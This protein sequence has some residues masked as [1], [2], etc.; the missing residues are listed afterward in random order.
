MLFAVLSSLVSF[1]VA[2][3]YGGPPTTPT[4]TAPAPAAPIPSAP[5]DTAGHVNINVAP[6]GSFVFSPA[7]VTAPN[8]TVVTFWFPSSS[9]QHSVT[10]SSFADP[11]TYLA[12][13]SNT[14]AGFDSGL[15]AADQFTITITNDQAPIW[16]HCKQVTHCGLGMVGSINAPQNGTK[17]F[18]AFQAAAKNIGSN[19][20]TETDHGFVSGGVNAVA[21]ASPSNTGVGA[22]PSTTTG[23]GSSGMKIGISIAAA[24]LG[25]VA[26]IALV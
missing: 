11:C 20:A 10:Q 6:G 23:S 4:T 8:G 17:T 24:L 14:S 25:G 5:S 7:N 2:Q 9:V 3:N 18:D 22:T 26:A 21:S 13:T 1:A 15:T 16:F 19:E 12:A